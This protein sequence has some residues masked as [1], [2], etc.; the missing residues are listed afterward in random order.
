MHF[1]NRAYVGTVDRGHLR[2]NGGKL[3][4]RRIDEWMRTDE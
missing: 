3:N 4:P 2:G 1:G